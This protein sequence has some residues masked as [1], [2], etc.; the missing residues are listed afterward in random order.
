MNNFNTLFDG[1]EEDIAVKQ[2]A[3]CK[4]VLAS[5]NFTWGT[6]FGIRK[7]RHECKKCERHLHTVRA[8]LRKI[9]KKPPAEFRCPICL[10]D[11]TE[12][13]GIGGKDRSVLC[14]DHDHDTDEFKGWLCHK[15]NRTLGGFYDDVNILAR[16]L[17]YVQT[18]NRRSKAR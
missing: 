18:V 8:N 7:Q 11:E 12:L 17:E 6:N 10:K 5:H 2:C 1:L 9:H 15:C 4:Q 16:A 14:V 13:Q 3:K